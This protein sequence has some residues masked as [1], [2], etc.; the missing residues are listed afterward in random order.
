MAERPEFDRSDSGYTQMFRLV[1]GRYSEYGHPLRDFPVERT[2]VVCM[3]ENAAQDT[4]DILQ[5]RPGQVIFVGSCLK[6]S[7]GIHRSELTQ[8]NVRDATAN[9]SVPDF[10]V[11]FLRRR[12]LFLDVVQIGNRFTERKSGS[13]P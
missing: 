10:R 8:P 3:S 11:T 2:L 12:P 6:H 5:G 9:V 1:H 7:A 4:L 13:V